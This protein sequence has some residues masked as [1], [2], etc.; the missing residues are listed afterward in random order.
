MVYEALEGGGVTHRADLELM[1]KKLYQEMEKVGLEPIIS[2]SVLEVF[3]D[4]ELRAVV[5]DSAFRLM[6]FRRME[7]EMNL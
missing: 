5:K 1:Y 7:G 6:R 4:G 3:T 2:L